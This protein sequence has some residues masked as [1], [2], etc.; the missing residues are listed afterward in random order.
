MSFITNQFWI[1][2]FMQEVQHISPTMIA[3]YLLAQAVFGVL[4]SYVGQALIHRFPGRTL[5]AIGSFAYLIGAV[6][7]LFNEKYTSYWA[8]L[9][10]SLVITVI[11]ADFQ[12][13][14]C[15]VSGSSCLSY[16]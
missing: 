11:G 14:V 5:M 2:L 9:F 8:F 1:S 4:W 15:S 6:L 12:F 16:S 7:Q 13:I 10:P 3:V